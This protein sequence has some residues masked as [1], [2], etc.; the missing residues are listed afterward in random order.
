MNWLENSFSPK[1]NQFASNPWIASVSEA[2]MK[3]LPFILVGSLIFLYNVFR[4][5][6]EFLPNLD[7]VLIF[8][9]QLISL[10]LVFMV[11]YEAM[12]KLEHHK[13]QVNAGIVSVI[14]YFMVCMPVIDDSNFMN[15]DYSKFGPSGMFAAIVVGLFVSIVYHFFDKLKL[16]ENNKNI[17]DFVSNWINQMIPIMICIVVMMIIV[18]VLNFDIYA[19]IIKLFEPVQ[20]FGSSLFGFVLICAVPVVLYTMGIST[21]FI[22]A[23]TTPILMSGTAANIAAVANGLPPENIV[24]YETVYALSLISLGGSGGTL[25]L[26]VLLMFSKTKKLKTLGRICIG[27]SIFNINEP[28]MFGTPVVFNPLLMLPA[29]INSIVGPIIIWIAMKIG[30]LAIPGAMMTSGQVPAPF[31]YILITGDFRALIFYVVLFVIYFMTWYP[32]FKVYE[33]QVV[34]EGNR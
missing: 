16:L 22:S 9:F 24:C 4:E 21:W 23:I 26:N 32:F 6:L 28:L 34:K 10:I 33:K 5:Y 14:V 12:D 25:P 31:G 1:M 8:T 18:N 2:M 20:Y 3:I 17:P 19:G 11:S 27:S 15:V 13:F 7:I 30:W 29:W